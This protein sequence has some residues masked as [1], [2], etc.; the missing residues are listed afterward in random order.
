MQDSAMWI[1]L[2]VFAAVVSLLVLSSRGKS[3]PTREALQELA[4]QTHG[5]FKRKAV[6]FAQVVEIQ[7]R[8]WPLT[9]EVANSLDGAGDSIASYQHLRSQGRYRMAQRFELQLQRKAA[10][11]PSWTLHS[12]GGTI[13][14][15][16]I[17]EIDHSFTVRTTDVGI[18]TAL[19]NDPSVSPHLTSIIRST[20]AM[21][22]G[23]LRN[24][25]LRSANGDIGAIIVYEDLAE[26]AVDHLKAI[27]DTMI[28]LLDALA[29]RQVALHP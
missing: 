19:L 22:V 8:G 27:Q 6:G 26:V 17:D 15:L 13:I 23:P 20:S 3:S 25:V 14:E 4:R 12:P 21:Y 24:G 9:F 28:S 5:T 2:L 1:A 18:A 29:Q 10:K 7:S 16:G 11:G